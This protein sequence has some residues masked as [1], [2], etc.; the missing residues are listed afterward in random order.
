MPARLLRAWRD[1]AF[2]LIVSPLLLAE[3]E[4]ALTYPK[5]R[6]RIEP[7]EAVALIELLRRFA[8]L[9]ADS[10]QPSPF[11]SADPHDDYLVTLAMQERAALVT[12]DGHLSDLATRLPVFSVADFHALLEDE[13]I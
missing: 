7:G 3:L 4:R 10:D 13:G 11:P 1:G 2:E 9:A 12:G 8:T 6:Q 5:L